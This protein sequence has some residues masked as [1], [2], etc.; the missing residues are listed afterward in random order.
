M[1]GPIIFRFS[2]GS[3]R[4]GWFRLLIILVL[5][6]GTLLVIAFVAFSL[7]IILAPLMLLAAVISYLFPGWRNRVRYPAAQPSAGDVIDADFRIVENADDASAKEDH[8]RLK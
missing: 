2:P 7:L 8:L 4:F 1:P 6:I 5:T 3:G